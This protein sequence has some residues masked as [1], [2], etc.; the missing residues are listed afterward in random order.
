MLPM[1]S[2]APNASFARPDCTLGD[3]LRYL[4]LPSSF[5][6]ADRSAFNFDAGG[7]ACRPQARASPLRWYDRAPGLLS[8]AEVLLVALVVVEH[9]ENA[10]KAREWATLASSQLQSFLKARE[11]WKR[12][13]DDDWS[14]SGAVFGLIHTAVT[15]IT[16][17]PAVLQAIAATLR[18][19]DGPGRVEQINAQHVANYFKRMPGS[20]W[21]GPPGP[22]AEKQ[23]S[24]GPRWRCGS[25]TEVGTAILQHGARM[26]K[27]LKLDIELESIPTH[28]ELLVQA[29]REVASLE[30]E[31]GWTK[32]D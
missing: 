3:S 12:P 15:E 9:A 19:W 27:F 22:R 18:S 32:H 1:V 25:V 13:D 5:F 14:A 30:M 16:A 26:R 28:E 24:G 7:D 29:R 8:D 4:A 31:L 23:R 21:A 10:S 2:F 11:A 6:S 20:S 17:K